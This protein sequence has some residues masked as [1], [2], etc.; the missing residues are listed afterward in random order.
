MYLFFQDQLA[1]PSFYPVYDVVDSNLDFSTFVL[2]D[3]DHLLKTNIRNMSTR[4]SKISK[5]L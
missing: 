2:S 3:K 5:S 4:L 1:M